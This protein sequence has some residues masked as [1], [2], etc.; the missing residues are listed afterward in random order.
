MLF[1]FKK[2]PEIIFFQDIYQLISVLDDNSISQVTMIFHFT[3]K[4]AHAFKF[5][6]TIKSLSILEFDQRIK[7]QSTINDESF[8]SKNAQTSKFLLYFF[9]LLITEYAQTVS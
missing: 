3:S 4:K 1:V 2:E 7:S 6:Y 5:Q 9:V 8:A